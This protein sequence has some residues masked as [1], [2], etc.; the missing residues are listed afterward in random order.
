MLRK[1]WGRYFDLVLA[2]SYS[3]VISD[4]ERSG[5][6]S[7]LIKISPRSSRAGSTEFGGDKHWSSIGSLS[8]FFSK[9][10]GGSGMVSSAGGGNASSYTSSSKSERGEGSNMLNS[11]LKNTNPIYQDKDLPSTVP[12]A[13]KE[14]SPQKHPI[15]QTEYPRRVSSV[16]FRVD[17]EDGSIPP[18]AIPK[19]N[20]M[21]N[22]NKDNG[23]SSNELKRTYT[24]ASTTSSSGGLVFRVPFQEKAATASNSPP[25]YDLYV[26]KPLD[27]KSQQKRRSSLMALTPADKQKINYP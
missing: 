6:Q 10:G 27:P 13:T 9:Q 3:N 4:Y 26:D 21:K 14:E 1:L 23:K 11:D 17:D 8:N 2:K 15:S 25:A 18:H 7:S 22:Y 16:S 24:S 20:N 12:F 5:A 19:N